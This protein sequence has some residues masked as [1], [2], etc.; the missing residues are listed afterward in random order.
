MK[1]DKKPEFTRGLLFPLDKTVSTIMRRLFV[2]AFLFTSGCDSLMVFK[3]SAQ[4]N[5]FV[6]G[7]QQAS[8]S[9]SSE[10]VSGAGETAVPAD[11]RSSDN[12]FNISTGSSPG[13][14][15]GGDRLL[16]VSS[17]ETMS[18]FP[19]NNLALSS[20]LIE[21]MNRNFSQCVIDSA[22]AAGISGNITNI[23]V[24]HMGGYVDRRVNNGSRSRNRAWSLH[25]SGRALDVGRIDFT[26]NGRSYRVPMTKRT[27]DGRDSTLGNQGRLF[28]RAFSSCWSEKNRN[29]CGSRA[30]LDCNYNS[31]HHDHIH[32]AVPFC[33]RKPGI[34]S[35]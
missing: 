27:H 17:T 2:L 7:K 14:G 15:R 12:R 34:A 35:S 4:Q 22:R 10:V 33:P 16:R 3:V 32:I 24:S 20:V 11:T 9:G 1:H 21:A 30:A 25:A 26:V 29:T 31:L 28:Y 23:N 13:R 6:T 19:R 5:L 18:F 8:A